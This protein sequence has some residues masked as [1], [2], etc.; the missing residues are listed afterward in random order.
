MGF[1]VYIKKNLYSKI[2][3]IKLLTLNKQEET[4]DCQE[5]PKDAEGT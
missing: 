2:F 3:K 1:K 5:L 4:G